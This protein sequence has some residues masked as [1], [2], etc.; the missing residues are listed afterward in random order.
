LAFGAVDFGSGA[1][2]IRAVSFFGPGE[3]SAGV[4]CVA[5]NRDAV[6][7]STGF[8]KF[9]GGGLNDIAWGDCVAE[10]I[11]SIAGGLGG[12]GGFG[13]WARPGKFGGFTFERAAVAAAANSVS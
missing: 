8:C 9:G 10:A 7:A 4:G 11:G 13:A 5:G 1:T 12:K 6:A 2:S 3:A